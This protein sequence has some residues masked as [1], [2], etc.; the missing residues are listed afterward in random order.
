MKQLQYKNEVWKDIKGF[1]GAYQIS[2][3]GRV[4]SLPRKQSRKE[5]IRVFAKAPN[6]YLRMVL[7]FENERRTI[8][9]HREVAKAFIPN[10]QNLETVNHI[11]FDKTNN[12]VENLEWVSHKENIQHNCNYDKNYHRPI[13]QKDLNG[14]IIRR[15]KSAYSVELEKGWFATNISR[16]C[17]GNKRTYKKFKWEFV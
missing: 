5:K 13:L 9:A 12:C 4:K 1:E 7:S 6:G 15:W 8:S 10:P 14:N 16:C 3:M 2:S 11:D 17:N